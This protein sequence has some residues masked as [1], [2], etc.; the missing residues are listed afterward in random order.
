LISEGRAIWIADAHRDDEKRFGVRVDA[1]PMAVFGNEAAI[2]VGSRA[3]PAYPNAVN[4]YNSYVLLRRISIGLK[5]AV[6]KK[7]ASAAV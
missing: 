7:L 4:R 6:L 5:P 3:A 1:K 2:R